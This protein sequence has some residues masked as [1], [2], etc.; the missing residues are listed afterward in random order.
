MQ[1]THGKLLKAAP[2]ELEDFM[3]QNN[4]PIEAHDFVGR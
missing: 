1:S 4:D 2:S 3:P